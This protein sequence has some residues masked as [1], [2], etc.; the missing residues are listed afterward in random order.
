M[1]GC[2]CLTL[3][4][5]GRKEEQILKSLQKEHAAFH[6]KRVC[7]VKDE[8]QV[9]TY[10]FLLFSLLNYTFLESVPHLAMLTHRLLR[11]K[12]TVM[13]SSRESVSSEIPKVFFFFSCKLFTLHSLSSGLI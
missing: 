12:W 6:S 7:V 10:F 5:R 8:P 13:F 2:C 1:S 9:F 3:A 11:M 4:N